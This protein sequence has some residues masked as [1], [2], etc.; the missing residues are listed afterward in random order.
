MCGESLSHP[1]QAGL[2]LT[3]GCILGAQG[4]FGVGRQM[5]GLYGVTVRER[6]ALQNGLESGSSPTSH[7]YPQLLPPLGLC[8]L[9]CKVG[10]GQGEELLACVTETSTTSRA[11]EGTHQSWGFGGP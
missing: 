5:F 10:V 1:S 4:N 6:R 8:E 2:T 11:W 3:N 9:I 7:V